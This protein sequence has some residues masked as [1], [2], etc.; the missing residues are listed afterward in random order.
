[1]SLPQTVLVIDDHVSLARGFSVALER[2]GYVA[3]T[4]HNAEDGLRLLQSARPDA[5]VLDFRMPFINGAGFLYRLREMPDHQHTPVL[6][7]TGGAVNEEMRAELR[8]L[9]AVLRFKP[10]TIRALLAEV[11]T[12][13]GEVAAPQ[14]VVS[15]TSKNG[16][17]QRPSRK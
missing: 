6:V 3:P 15:E 16:D 4:A 8:E 12:L 10:L 9:N 13:L 11:R 17:V 2:E 1:M 7:V 5:I 14:A